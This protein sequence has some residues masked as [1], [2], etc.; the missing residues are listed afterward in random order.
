MVLYSV[1]TRML[2]ELLKKQGY[3][4]QS[5]S[6]YYVVNVPPDLALLGKHFQLHDVEASSSLSGTVCPRRIYS[7]S[8][9]GKE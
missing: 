6:S 3:G 7:N 2:G 5:I 4:N 1:C 8:G 9:A